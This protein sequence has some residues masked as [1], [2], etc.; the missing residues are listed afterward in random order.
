M[1]RSSAV[2]GI[3]T[4]TFL[5][6]YGLPSADGSIENDPALLRDALRAGVRY[7]DTAAGYGDS[8]IAVAR[9][10]RG[11]EGV[12]VCTKISA[13]GTLGEIRSS[14]ERLESAPDTILV[15]SAGRQQIESAPAIA[16]LT[17]ARVE[18]LTARIG[19]S[20]YGAED[21]GLA[22]A[23][24]WVDVVQ[25][26]YSILNQSV[27]DTVRR[28]RP[29]QEVVVR[30]VLCKG[31]L[32]GR[33][34]AAPQLAAQVQAALDG[35]AGCAREWGY[36]I[37]GLAIRFALDTPGIDVVLVG[38]SNH[39]ELETALSTAA[40]PPLTAGQFERVAAFDRRDADAAHPERWR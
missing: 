37:E 11:I 2:L 22:L 29:E 9:A 13:A 21:A 8:E 17:R 7:V 3:G 28:S 5:P 38:V 33:R 34:S 16:S 24:P 19:A 23:Q 1:T 20:T 27:I 36:G 35:I 32:T 6:N 25:V 26:E 18:G 14:I 15:H 30:S 10:V 4:A 31:L 39:E 12:R 40:R